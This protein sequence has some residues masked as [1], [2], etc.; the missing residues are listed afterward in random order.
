MKNLAPT[1][2]FLL[3]NFLNCWSYFYSHYPSA[4]CTRLFFAARYRW[5]FQTGSSGRRR[6]SS[7]RTASR[8]T[9][10]CG[11]ASARFWSSRM[12]ATAG[13]ASAGAFANISVTSTVLWTWP[14]C[15][16]GTVLDVDLAASGFSMTT[17][18][19]S[20]LATTTSSRTSRS[21]IS[22]SKVYA[23][24]FVAPVVLPVYGKLD[25][26]IMW[27]LCLD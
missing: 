25:W 9:S 24:C 2:S 10:G 20:G 26:T 17:S 15:S 11:A 16:T 23:A 14:T 18:T 7:M 8:S 4:V 22:A 13:C 21:D 27:Q 5:A 6:R 1:K 19:T 12:H 3:F